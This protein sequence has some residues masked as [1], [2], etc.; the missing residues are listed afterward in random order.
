MSEKLIKV[1]TINREFIKQFDHD[2]DLLSL[3][4]Y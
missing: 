1:F 2:V 4:N 3:F